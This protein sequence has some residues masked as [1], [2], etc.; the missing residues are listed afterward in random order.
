MSNET[1][2]TQQ[3]IDTV[4]NS[5]EYT[6]MGH[7]FQNK[8]FPVSKI[9][10]SQEY[11][12]INPMK[13]GT[14]RSYKNVTRFSNFLFEMD[15]F[16]KRDQAEIMKKCG[17][18]FSTIVDSSNKSLHFLVCLDHDLGDRTM[19]TAYFKAMK[20]V[21]EK[22][23][24]KIDEACKDPGRFTRSPYGVNTKLELSEKKPNIHDRIQKPKW[25]GTR[26]SLKQ[27][28]EWLA[29]ND[30]NPLD[31]IQVP[32]VRS[33]YAGV[34]SSADD[35]LKWEWI[36]KYFMKDDTFEEGNIHNYQTKMIYCLLRT[37]MVADTIDRMLIQKHETMSSG[38]KSAANFEADGDP[39][40]VPTMEERREYYRAQDEQEALERKRR[41]Y[42]RDD[43]PKTEIEFRPEEIDRYLAVGTEYFK[44]DS[45]TDELI[46]WTKTMF[47]KL[48]GGRSTP[49]LLYDKF[50]YRPDYISEQ[51]PHNLGADG[52]TRNRFIRPDWRA[53]PGNWDTIKTGLL[54]GFGDQFDLALQYCAISILYPEAK[55]PAI[56]FVG[57]EESGKTSVIQIIISLV[58]RQAYKKIGGKQLESDFTD[59]LAESQLVVVEESGNWKNPEAVMDNLKDW[60]TE[61]GQQTVNPKYGKQYKSP[62]HCKFVFSSNNYDALHLSGAATRFWVREMDTAPTTKI[63]QYKEKVEA[64][65]GHFVDYLL[66][67]VGPKLR[68]DQ[69]GNLDTSRSRLYFAPE[70]YATKIKGFIQD[71]ANSELYEQI[72]DGICKH[73]ETYKDQDKCFVDLDS[74]KDHLG[75]GKKGMPNNKEIKMC[76]KNEFKKDRSTTIT[77]PDS[78]RFDPKYKTILEKQPTRRGNWWIFDRETVMD[79]F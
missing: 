71:L 59:F 55:L 12:S 16:S 25:I 8:T 22:F 33:D 74:I 57:G 76:M 63:S 11:V 60:I 44:I 10:E 5:G 34:H 18:P 47:E 9:A 36:E 70:D 38:I 54:H 35:E 64:E 62:I 29:T 65:M 6:C 26:T 2:L 53:E 39:I 3:W 46:P 75:L 1:K 61:N 56:L 28:D 73:F 50:G 40:Y 42:D 66:T 31:F 13:K 52:K 48:Y 4:F 23:G 41:G 45:V 77:R 69:N 20:T 68:L 79:I 78:F 32:T 14:T 67:Y 24:G 27:L 37:G 17:L 7:K 49:P 43:I 58:G 19:Y 51:F 30:V 72:L 21:I 15:H